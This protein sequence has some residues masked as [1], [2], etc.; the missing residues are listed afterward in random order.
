[1]MGDRYGLITKIGRKYL[2][3]LLDKSN[4]NIPILPELIYEKIS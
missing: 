1:M 4:K 3:V 2:H